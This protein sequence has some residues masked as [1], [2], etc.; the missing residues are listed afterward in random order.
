MTK[1]ELIGCIAEKSGLAKKDSE[2]ALNAIVDSITA[3]LVEGDKV[4]LTGF[5]AFEVKERPE[6]TGRNP[7]TKEIIVIPASRSVVFK[8]GK[9]LKDSVN[10]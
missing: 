5:G 7:Q 4:Q 3:A 2:S 6:R 9:V 8:A 1:N 10:A